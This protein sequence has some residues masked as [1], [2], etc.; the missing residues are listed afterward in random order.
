MAIFPF[1]LSTT[2]EY[3]KVGLI[4][5][6]EMIVANV[7][8]M[9]MDR[10]ILRFHAKGDWP[11]TLLKSVFTV[12]ACF[13]WIPFAVTLALYLAGWETL[14]S[15]P[16]APHLLLLSVITSLF[17]L[18][19][20]CICIGRAQR[21]LP[22][23]LR[24][25]LGYMALKLAAVLAFATYSGDSISY[26]L[27]IAA[28]ALIMLVVIFPFLYRNMGGHSDWGVVRQL[29]GFGWPFVFHIFS[30][31][32]L[33][34]FSR[35]FLEAYN[36]TTDVG[37]FTFAFT[38]GSALYVGYAALAT[39][40]EPQIYAHSGDVARCE[41]WLG[42]Y[43]NVCLTFASAGGALLLIIFPYLV[44]TLPSDYHHAL[45]TISMVLGTILLN[46][47][48][49][50]GNYRLT[51]HKK[52]EQIAVASFLS[53]GLSLVLNYA[54]IPPYGIWGAAMAMYISNLILC[55]IVVGVSLKTARIPLS[56]L[57]IRSSFIL[58]PVGSLA[59]L[60][61]A[62]H[63]NYAIFTLIIVSVLSVGTLLSLAVTRGN[64]KS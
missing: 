4:V 9:G 36:S 47:L 39:Y 35:F 6:I 30:A 13:S 34:Y 18:N 41:R 42:I 38:L 7:T 61:A 63:S 25:R 2:E 52:T 1:F 19:F 27:G 29:L 32:I 22:I 43:T 57:K 33:G 26:V 62:N 56:H 21:K 46:P 24:F 20:L 11:D 60:L 17:N 37:I 15:I 14:F 49:L 48:Y 12:W 45:P 40:F 44:P 55:A 54:L 3:G 58:C 31:N 5:S 28:A 53:A 10:A 16:V 59:V 64:V 50:Q 51:A 8:L 23:F